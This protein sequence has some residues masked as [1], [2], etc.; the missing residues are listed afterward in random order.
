MA[1]K[2]D[3]KSK[4][5]DMS[6]SQVNKQ[7]GPGSITT[8]TADDITAQGTIEAHFGFLGSLTII[9]FFFIILFLTK[10]PFG[11]F[12]EQYILFPLSIG[13]TRVEYFLFPLE[14]SRIF[15]RFKLI[16]IP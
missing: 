3:N 6:I 9:S 16:H 4:A 12:Y 2:S 15:L 11:S 10:I 1:A 14:F 13:K 7:F 8:L 5:L